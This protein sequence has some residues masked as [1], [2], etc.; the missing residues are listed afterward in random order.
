MRIPKGAPRRE[1][2]EPARRDIG[3]FGRVHAWAGVNVAIL[4]FSQFGVNHAEGG[5]FV[6]PPRGDQPARGSSQIGSPLFAAW[7]RRYPHQSRLSR[8]PVRSAPRSV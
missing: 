4:S 3:E 1:Y 7:R 5:P 2:Y 6:P 8:K